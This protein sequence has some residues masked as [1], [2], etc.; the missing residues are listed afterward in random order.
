MKSF[1][2]ESSQWQLGVCKLGA[3]M[4]AK[5]FVAVTATCRCSFSVDFI[6]DTYFASTRFLHVLFKD[7]SINRQLID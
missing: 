4:R 6:G 1:D 3:K 7:Y 5:L 2:I